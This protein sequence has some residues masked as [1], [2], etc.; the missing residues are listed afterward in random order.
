M[1]EAFGRLG[2]FPLLGRRRDDL[3]PDLRSYAVEQHVILYRLEDEGIVV[4]RVVHAR[5]DLSRLSIP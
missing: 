2:E 5:R 1:G 4:L 3:R